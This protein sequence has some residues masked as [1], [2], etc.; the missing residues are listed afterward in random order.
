MKSRFSEF[1]E[2]ILRASGWSP[3]RNVSQLVIQWKAEIQKTDGQEMF[4]EA[5]KILIE[6]GGLKI[7]QN[8]PNKIYSRTSVEINPSL[9][10]YE[11]DRFEVFEKN[12]EINLYPLGE[13]DGGHS[14]LTVGEDGRIFLVM[15]NVWFVA[16]SFDEALENLILGKM[17]QFID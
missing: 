7:K 4:P 8:Y 11:S 1:T 2:T 3:N 9:V 6:F 12:L 5:E 14:F 13:T 16:N 17:P 15:M 10:I